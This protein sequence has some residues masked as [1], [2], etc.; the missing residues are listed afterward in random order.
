MRISFEVALTKLVADY[1]LVIDNGPPVAEMAA[2]LL[3]KAQV[4]LAL[5]KS[6]EAEECRGCDQ[7]AT[8]DGVC[9][10]CAYEQWLETQADQRAKR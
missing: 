2:A 7:P 6:W 3:A 10:D 4:L 5:M 9:D 1:S 8:A